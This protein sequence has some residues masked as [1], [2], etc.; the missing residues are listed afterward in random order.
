MLNIA[1]AQADIGTEHSPLPQFVFKLQD[2]LRFATIAFVCELLCV[3]PAVYVFAPL[4]GLGLPSRL[5]KLLFVAGIPAHI[6][7]QLDGIVR[8]SFILIR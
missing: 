5:L 4:F 1:S 8:G 2:G 6:L 3:F 7:F